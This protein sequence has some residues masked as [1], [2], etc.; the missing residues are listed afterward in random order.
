MTEQN[1]TQQA[2]QYI[3]VIHKRRGLVIGCLHDR[4]IH[5]PIEMLARQKKRLD[6]EGPGWH[7]VLAATGQPA[8]FG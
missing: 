1:F 8:R 3:A 6:P 5:I 7:A 2:R 4:F